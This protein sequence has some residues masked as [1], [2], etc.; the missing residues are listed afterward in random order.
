[1]HHIPVVAIKQVRVSSWIH[2][3]KF[4][5]RVKDAATLLQS[6]I[7]DADREHFV[8]LLMDTKNQIVG[9]QTVST[10]TLNQALVHPRE[11]FKAA[12]LA[13]AS[14]IICAH[15]HPSG[16]LEPS[17]EDLTVTKRLV[18]AGELIGIEVM[19]HI[20]VSEDSYHSM[21]EYGQM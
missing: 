8:I 10:G 14:G 18:E 5:R 12:I 6:L 21:R 19:D 1:M 11:V 20:I 4:V 7:G 15:N 13:N 2:P 17:I 3:V 16:V 9:I